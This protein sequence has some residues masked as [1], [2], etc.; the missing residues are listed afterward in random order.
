[1]KKLFQILIY[2]SIFFLLIRLIKTDFLSVPEIKN[3]LSLVLSIFFLFAGF[4]FQGITWKIILNN[5][6]IGVSYKYSVI[7]DSLCIFM[8]YIPGKVLAVLGRASYLSNS[9][10]INLFIATSASFFSQILV[11]WTGLILGIAILL[12]GELSPIINISSAISI[13]LI[14]AILI[15]PDSFIKFTK[16]IAKILK[17]E[18]KLKPL[19]MS[20]IVGI[21]PYF[22]A[23][24]LFWGVGFYFF[25]GA[26]TEY[27]I[28]LYA[29][30]AFPFATSLAIIV[31]IAPGGIGIRE[32]TL[33]GCL[34]LLSFPISEASSIAISSRIWF[35]F[36]EFIY[37]MT[38]L[39]LK[40]YP[41]K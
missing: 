41:K 17:K 34:I 12:S 20:K 23:M 7:S 9:K 25:S 15:Y 11:V 31:L 18:I 36:G 19:P 38:G 1:M 22:F 28:N 2:A 24:W 40:N 32:G 5:F 13:L 14:T 3:Y 4:L 39:A 26:I 21:I 27:E 33:F 30:L 29:I 10:N 6:N 16:I 8:K 35:L 37:F